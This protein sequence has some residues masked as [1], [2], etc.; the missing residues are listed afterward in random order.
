MRTCSL[1][2]RQQLVDELDLLAFNGTEADARIAEIIKRFITKHRKLTG[3]SQLDAELR[4]ADEI[5]DLYGLGE[6]HLRGL[7]DVATI[8]DRVLC[9]FG[10][11][12]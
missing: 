8:K 4:F 10:L 11:D 1:D 5:R 7:A 2:Y 12:W 9:Y 6:S 3:E